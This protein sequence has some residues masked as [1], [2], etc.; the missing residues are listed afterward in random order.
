MLLVRIMKNVGYQHDGLKFLRI[1]VIERDGCQAKNE[2]PFDRKP[3]GIEIKK[4]C[5]T[6]K[7]VVLLKSLN[8]L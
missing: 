7:L 3:E 4:N 6:T 2:L 8:D 5:I 1:D